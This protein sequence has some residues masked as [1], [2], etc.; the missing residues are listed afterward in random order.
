MYGVSSSANTGLLTFS[1]HDAQKHVQ[2]MS[3]HMYL[4]IFM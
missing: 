3:M 2:A 1:L 4:K